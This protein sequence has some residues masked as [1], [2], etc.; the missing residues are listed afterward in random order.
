MSLILFD[1]R[2]DNVWVLLSTTLLE[3]DY[4]P[5]MVVYLCSRTDIVINNP[6]LIFFPK[7]ECSP[8]TYNFSTLQFRS[9]I[10][11][12]KCFKLFF[13]D[14]SSICIHLSLSCNTFS[15]IRAW[16]VEKGDSDATNWKT[17][18]RFAQESKNFAGDVNMTSWPLWRNLT[19]ASYALTG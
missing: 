8:I 19:L 13:V 14:I 4:I 17:S 6:A 12:C 9:S 10:C 1:S 16:G 18:W 11:L 5:V 2:G 3:F 15:G 7:F